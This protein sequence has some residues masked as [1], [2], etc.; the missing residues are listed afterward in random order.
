MNNAL[1]HHFRRIRQH[2]METFGGMV[3]RYP[4]GKTE[5]TGGGAIYGEHALSALMQAKS[6]IRFVK[7]LGKRVRADK[8]R[9]AAARKGWR[10]R[11]SAQ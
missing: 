5:L 2:Q 6:H 4:S 8:K 1:R 10:T 3:V 11:R 9:S 7:D